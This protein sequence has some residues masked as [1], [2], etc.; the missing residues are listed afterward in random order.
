MFR[1]IKKLLAIACVTVAVGAVTIPNLVS[2][3]NTTTPNSTE[4]HKPRGDGWK[5]LNLTDAQKAQIKTIRESAK[6]RSQSVLTAEQRAIM[7]Q[8]RQSG[9]RKGV[10]KSL[11]LTDAQKQQ[12]KAIAEDTKAQMKNVLTPAQQQQLEQM[13][14][15]RQSNRGTTR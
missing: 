5:Q 3:Q 15:Q 7:E 4:K 1:N 13:K 9:D 6:T 2:A 14:Q 10:R 8:A 11:N 12:M